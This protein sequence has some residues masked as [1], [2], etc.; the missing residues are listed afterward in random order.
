MSTTAPQPQNPVPSSITIRQARD[1]DA[2]SIRLLVTKALLAADLDTPTAEVDSD[3][4][5]PGYYREPGRG[6]WVAVEGERIVGCAAIDRGEEGQATLRRLAGVSLA[7]LTAAAVAFSR[8][9]GYR[10]VETVLPAAMTNA[11]EAVAAEGFHDDNNANDLIF[12]LP[13]V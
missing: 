9:R 12:R 11:R 2:L 7:D 10:G 1:E 3:L 13:L 8:G 5:G 4:I 6:M